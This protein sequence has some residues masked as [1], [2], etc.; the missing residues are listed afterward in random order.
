MLICSRVC[1]P[2]GKANHKEPQT[3]YLPNHENAFIKSALKVAHILAHNSNYMEKRLHIKK[4][5]KNRKAN[6]SLRVNKNEKVKTSL[7]VPS[8]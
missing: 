8:H 3:M 6:F 4:V 7:V 2:W 5:S 1:G